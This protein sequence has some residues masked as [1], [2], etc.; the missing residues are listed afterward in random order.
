MRRM[1]QVIRK[2][3]RTAL[4]QWRDDNGRLLRGTIPAEQVEESEQESTVDQSVLDMSVP[5]GVSWQDFMSDI[6]I[7][8]EDVEVALHNAG[9][10]T[11]QD[12][13]LNPSTVNGVFISLVGINLVHLMRL[14]EQGIDIL[15]D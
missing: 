14:A 4:V 8:A 10:W 13:R 6:Y 5:Y 3:N 7:S 15:E 1:V 2:K 12:M 11:V 9:V